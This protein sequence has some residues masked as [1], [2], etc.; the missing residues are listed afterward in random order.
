MSDVEIYSHDVLILGTGLAGLRAAVEIARKSDDS[1][2]MA[3]V[4]KVQLM[5]AHSVCAEG[6]TAA[7]L[8]EEE[9]DSFELH[10]W[11]TIKGSDFLADQDVVDLFVRKMPDEIRQLEHWGVP[12]TRREDGRIDQRPFGGHSYPR[13]TLAADKTGFFEMQGLY[14]TLLR[15]KNFD[16]YE[17]V[18]ATSFLIDNGKIAGITAIDLPSGK[19]IVIKAKAVLI[20]TGGL[21]TLYGFT[22]YSQT[23]SG[24]GQA[25]AYKAGMNLEDLEFIQFHP[26]GLVPSGI[27]MTEGCRGEGGYLRDKDDNRFMEKYA[28]KFMETAPRDIVSRSETTEILEG[29]GI[30]SSDGGHHLQLDLIHLGADKINKK[31]PLIRELCMKFLGIDPIH[32]QIPIRPVAHYSMGGIETDI[33]GKTSYANAWAAGEVACVSLHGANRLGSNSTAECLVWGGICGEEI[34]KYLKSGEATMPEVNEADIKAEGDKIF[35]DLLKRDGEENPYDIRKDLR[36]LMGDHMG[37]YRTGE[38]MA[39]GL[40]KVK[41]LIKRFENIK[42]LDKGLSYNTNLMNVIELENLL[43]LAEAAIIAALAREE[44]R[45]GHARRDFPD[46]DDEKWL[47]HTLITKSDEGPR[48]SYKEVAIDKWL[49]VERKY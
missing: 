9:G 49:P 28:A 37:V 1:I 31:L 17:E 42:V 47:K 24:D 19:F 25:M 46:R 29:R 33:M 34:V 18:F 6:G 8:R 10:A 21:G 27:L 43:M 11:D 30:P 12:W 5:R 26:T 23:V 44:S 41:A 32:E 40:E 3:L 7:V 4:S 15:N 45:G 38:L 48:L 16:R 20:A 22:T 35:N 13:A 14:D 36:A 39:Q 2:N